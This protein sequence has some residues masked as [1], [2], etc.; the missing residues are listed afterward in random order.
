MKVEEIKTYRCS[1]GAVFDSKE[2]AESHEAD[3]KDPNYLLI[4]RIEELEKK[5]QHL[6]GENLKR[7]AEIDAIKTPFRLN[8]KE[9]WLQQPMVKWDSKTDEDGNVWDLFSWAFSNKKDNK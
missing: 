2:V 1:D 6:E 4:K 8:Q 9:P 3:L 5:V 7:I